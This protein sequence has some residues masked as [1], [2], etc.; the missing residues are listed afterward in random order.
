[1]AGQGSLTLQTL[2][3]APSGSHLLAGGV[4]VKLLGIPADC[5]QCL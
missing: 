1:M 4:F 3:P 2:V 5:A